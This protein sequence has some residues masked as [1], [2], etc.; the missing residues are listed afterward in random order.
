[1]TRKQ[2]SKPSD[3]PAPSPRTMARIAEAKLRNAGRLER[4]SIDLELG[5]RHG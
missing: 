4:P 3:R 1:M 2:N 5:V